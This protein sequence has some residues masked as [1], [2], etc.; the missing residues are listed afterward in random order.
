MLEIGSCVAGAWFVVGLSRRRLGCSGSMKCDLNESHDPWRRGSFSSFAIVDLLGLAWTNASHAA[1]LISHGLGS[2]VV[3]TSE[4]SG[5]DGSAKWEGSTLNPIALAAGKFFQL[6]NWVFARHGTSSPLDGSY[7]AEGIAAGLS[8]LLNLRAVVACEV[9]SMGLLSCHGGRGNRNFRPTGS[10]AFRT[11]L[12]GCCGCCCCV[13]LL[14]LRW[15]A[16]Q[17]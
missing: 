16:P 1:R 12:S 4:P 7:R 17:C 2:W 3:V 9:R 10:C 14:L 11:C 15:L 5:R 13:V 6:R 8:W